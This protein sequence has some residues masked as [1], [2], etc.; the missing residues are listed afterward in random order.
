MKNNIVLCGFMGSGKTTVGKA[1]AEALNF[2]FVDSDY[3]VQQK[4]GRTISEIFA[5]NGEEYFRNAET[6]ALKEL[7]TKTNTVIATGGGAVLKAENI[8]LLKSSGLVVFLDVSP[9]TV[10]NRLKNDT[11]RPLL[12]RPDRD[13]VIREL[14]TLR[15]PLYLTAAD[16][17][18][19]AENN[20]Q[21]TSKII[22]EKFLNLQ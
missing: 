3:Y 6:E 11:T 15:K 14:L 16:V 22:V 7:A 9:E 8:S 1:V 17:V 10:I 20:A 18:L 13:N 21:N 2:E 19:T 12:M 4:L 5:E